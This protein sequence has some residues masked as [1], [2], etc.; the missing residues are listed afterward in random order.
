MTPDKHNSLGPN[1]IRVTGILCI[2]DDGRGNERSPR[3]SGNDDR[4]S[5]ISSGIETV[6]R[7]RG[8]P[9]SR[10]L[11]M[12]Q[13][14]SRLRTVTRPRAISN[15][16]TSQYGPSSAIAAVQTGGQR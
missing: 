9:M 1:S 7:Q 11:C 2:H 12:Q 15:H 3:A 6:S 10:R 4:V 16:N 14:P 13:Q 8:K 5:N